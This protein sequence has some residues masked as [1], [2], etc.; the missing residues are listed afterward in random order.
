MAQEVNSSMRCTS[1]I[2]DNVLVLSLLEM[3]ANRL[4]KRSQ[5]SG[6]ELDVKRSDGRSRPIAPFI[7]SID[8]TRG[9]LF[10]LQA[11]LSYALMLAV[12]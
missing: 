8:L 9:A 6:S 2:T 12:M 1:A 7:P 4:A 11:F 5:D 10:A 3:N